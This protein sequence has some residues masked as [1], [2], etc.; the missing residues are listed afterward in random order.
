MKNLGQMMKQAQ[1]MQEKMGSLQEE[2]AQL[3]VTGTS[4]GGMVKLTMTGKHEV[5][6]IDIDPSL[7]SADEREVLEDLLAAAFNDAKT[8]VEEMM[9]EKM[10]ELTGGMQLPPGMSLPF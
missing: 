5:K 8:K 3:E 4:G 2:L 7:M 9:K 10:A 6:K 1:Q